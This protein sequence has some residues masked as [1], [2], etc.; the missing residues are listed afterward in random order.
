MRAS[1][2]AVLITKSLY[3]RILIVS[4]LVSVA[5]AGDMGRAAAAR[6]G[7]PA[8]AQCASVGETAKSMNSIVKMSLKISSSRARTMQLLLLLPVMLLVML[9]LQ[10]EANGCSA[11]VCDNEGPAQQMACIRSSSSSSSNS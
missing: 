1:S 7:A 9:L 3:L 2:R 5:V 6:H 8:A 11:E 10:T 4:C